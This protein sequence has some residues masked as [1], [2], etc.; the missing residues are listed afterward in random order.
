MQIGAFK[1]LIGKLDEHARGIKY[2]YGPRMG[3]TR[4]A[5]DAAVHQEKHR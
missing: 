1:F 5:I 2:R 4:N 3:N